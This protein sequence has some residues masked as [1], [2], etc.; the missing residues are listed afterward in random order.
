MV[1][2]VAIE[3]EKILISAFV[4]VESAHFFSAYLP[5]IFTIKNLAIPQKAENNIRAGYIPAT[6]LSLALS[7]IVSYLVKSPYPLIFGIGTIALMITFYE[8]A[9]MGVI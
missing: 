3:I 4:G 7:G 6:L 8:L 1:S 2:K 5:S 9:L